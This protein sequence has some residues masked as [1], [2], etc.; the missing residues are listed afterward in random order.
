MKYII[1]DMEE[2]KVT[3][4]FESMYQSLSKEIKEYVPNTKQT[5]ID[6][7]EKKD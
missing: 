2:K 6:T 7:K 1:C 3:K 4:Q 5:S